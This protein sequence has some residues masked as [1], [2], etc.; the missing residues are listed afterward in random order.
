MKFPKITKT[1][2]L[3]L[4]LAM[5]TSCAFAE[6]GEGQAAADTI[7][8]TGTA[9]YTLELAEFFDIDVN[10]AGGNS[11]TTFGTDYDTITIDKA[12]VGEFEVVSNTDSKNV[13]LKGTCATSDGGDQPAIYGT[14]GVDNTPGALK[15]VFTNDRVKPT[16]TA[17]SNLTTGGNTSTTNNANAIAFA[18]VD[19]YS[20]EESFLD[21]KL[22]SAAS[23]SNGVISYGIYNG[24]H[25]FKYTVS[26]ANSVDASFSTMDTNGTYKATLTFTDVPAN[27][28]Q[29]S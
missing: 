14:P 15:I 9:V 13:Y 22:Q 29:G 12:I 16:K 19:N 23:L 18:L 20:S 25:K 4:A 27:G 1:L 3:V 6:E 8:N 26:A 11:T 2:P 28:G 21:N 17:V 5:T 7:S 24:K 10:Q